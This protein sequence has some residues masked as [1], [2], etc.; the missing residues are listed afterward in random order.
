MEI[1]LN[2]T[3][4]AYSFFCGVATTLLCGLF[5]A[6]SGTRR[7]LAHSLAQGS[8]TQASARHPLQWFLVAVQ[9]TLAV[10]LLTGAGLLIRSL[11]QLGRVSPASI[12]ATSSPFRSA[13]PGAR[14]PTCP[15]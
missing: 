2:W 8:R 4:A 12:P 15:S 6:L 5:P 9:V 7:T 10:T 14:L 11:Q 13:A 3:V 1:R